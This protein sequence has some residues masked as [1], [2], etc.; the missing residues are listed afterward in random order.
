MLWGKHRNG[1]YV[2]VI[3]LRSLKIMEILCILLKTL[4]F[5]VIENIELISMFLKE[6]R[7][8]FE[9]YKMTWKW[10]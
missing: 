10:F 2:A 6:H 7:I 1:F 9:A 8:G 3:K 4:H 5:N